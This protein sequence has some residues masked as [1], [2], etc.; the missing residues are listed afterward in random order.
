MG[1]LVPACGKV[2]LTKLIR[3]FP[4]MH[5]LMVRC[6][7]DWSANQPAILEFVKGGYTS[8]SINKG[9]PG[10]RAARHRNVNKAGIIVTISM[11]RNVG[12]KLWV[13]PQDD[14]SQ[15]VD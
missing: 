14:K 6:L 5:W 9:R 1:G 11:D 4:T 12:G 15:P 10:Y 3:K 2:C 8:F 7:H 13:W